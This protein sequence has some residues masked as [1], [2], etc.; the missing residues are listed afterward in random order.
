MA[1]TDTKTDDDWERMARTLTALAS[2]V[3]MLESRLHQ[4]A[5]T[6]R[7]AETDEQ[8]CS[9]ADELDWIVG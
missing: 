3:N 5:R 2:R 9:V 6:L 7:E 8:R 4:A 1:L